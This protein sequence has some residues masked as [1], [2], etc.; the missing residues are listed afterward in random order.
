M[1][2]LTVGNNS[3]DM[4]RGIHQRDVCVDISFSAKI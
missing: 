2:S 3:F 4:Y 1:Y